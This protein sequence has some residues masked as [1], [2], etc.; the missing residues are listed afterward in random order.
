MSATKN[1]LDLA[2]I[3]LAKNRIAAYVASTPLRPWNYLQK[4]LQ[5]EAPVFLK[6]ESLQNTGAFKVR[7]AA[8]KILSLI[9]EGKTPKHVVAASAGNHAQAVAFV[10]GRLGIPT[11][12]VMPQGSPLVKVSATQDYGAKVVLSGLVYDEAYAKAQEILANTPGAVYV[13]A[14]E[15]ED[16]ISGQGT[17]GI[18]IHEQLSQLGIKDSKLQV[19]IPIGGGGLFSGTAIALRALRPESTFFGVVSHAAPAMAQSFQKGDIVSPTPSRTRTLAEGLAVKKVSALTF[20]IIKNLAKE[21]SIVDDEEISLAI[22]LLM[23]RGKL[24]SEGSGAAGVA[25]ALAG[26]FPGLDPK[27]PTVFVLCGG[28]I[29]MN[30]VS[31]IL[32]RGLFKSKRWLRLFITVEDRPGELARASAEIANLGGNILE[33]QHDRLS[34]PV[35]VGY[36]GLNFLLETRGEEH[37][38]A[39]QKGLGD[40]GFQIRKTGD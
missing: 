21:I 30:T 15:D 40:K 28:N 3:G 39:L 29:D 27:L 7:G 38:I 23:E 13:H 16:I 8:N 35:L 19:V 24:V 14:Y 5:F 10:A 34:T 12:I 11:T 25:A 26:K 32:E 9:E 20:S 4:A 18:E 37:A 17:L 31:Q 22:A 1:V 6:L 36:T 2:R 33:V